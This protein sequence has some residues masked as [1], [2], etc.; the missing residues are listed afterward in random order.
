MSTKQEKIQELI[1][2]QKKFIEYEHKNG[3]NSQDYYAPEAGHELDGYKE[4]Y[5]DV[6]LDVMQAAHDEVGSS[7]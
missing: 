7:R 6:A 5:Q 1:A 3:L 2:M 4:K